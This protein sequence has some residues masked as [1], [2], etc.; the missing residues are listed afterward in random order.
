V[1]FLLLCVYL[2]KVPAK[3]VFTLYFM[4]GR[5]LSNFSATLL[6]RKTWKQSGNSAYIK[7]SSFQKIKYPKTNNYLQN[8]EFIWTDISKFIICQKVFSHNNVFL[9]FLMLHVC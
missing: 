4:G 9:I 5:I 8:T 3:L 7:K 1:E 6:G 2:H